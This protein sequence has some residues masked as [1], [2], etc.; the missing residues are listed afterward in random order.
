MLG[1]ALNAR[2]KDDP[3]AHPEVWH[4]VY[5]AAQCA[6]DY[7]QKQLES[8]SETLRSSARS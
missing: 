7:D 6:E 3:T 4:V 8:L 5:A 2:G 1:S